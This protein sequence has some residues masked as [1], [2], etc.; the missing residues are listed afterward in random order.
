[1]TIAVQQSDDQKQLRLKIIGRLELADHRDFRE[2]YL[3]TDPSEVSYIVDLADTQSID[4]AT[5]GMLLAMREELG[6]EK[7]V[8]TLANCSPEII[9]ILSVTNIARL[10]VIQ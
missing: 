10:F 7:V 4:S 9:K 8:I 1:M 6:G 5:L 3:E 2:A